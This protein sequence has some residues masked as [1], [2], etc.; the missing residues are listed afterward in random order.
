MRDRLGQEASG[1][2]DQRAGGTT[3]KMGISAEYFAIS[4]QEFAERFPGWALPPPL[5][6]KPPSILKGRN[7]FTGA[8]IRYARHEGVSRPKAAPDADPCPDTGGLRSV[9]AYGAEW[10]CVAHLVALE[11]GEH[12]GLLFADLEL[13]E[14]VPPERMDDTYCVLPARM[15]EA[16]ARIHVVPGLAEEWALA[17][18]GPG[19]RAGEWMAHVLPQLVELARYAV[20]TNRLIVGCA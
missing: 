19:N 16:L 11:S 5:P 7:P 1:R 14:L 6:E 20:E 13:C 17:A 4:K 2:A 9:D 8:L 15:V 10:S 12:V 18:F 3:R